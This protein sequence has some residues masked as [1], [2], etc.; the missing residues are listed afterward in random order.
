LTEALERRFAIEDWHNFGPDYDR[1]L[2]AWWANFDAG[3]P[4]LR[5][6]YSP[7]FHR[8]WKYYL[9]SCAG[10][11]RARQGQLWQL[12][13]SKRQRLAVYRSVR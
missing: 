5:N 13:L 9:L 8:M 3:W 2:M 10:F 7:R 6:R 12:V 4:R 1:T 11:F